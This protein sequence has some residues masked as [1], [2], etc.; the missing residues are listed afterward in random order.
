M[1]HKIVLAAVIFLAFLS[2]SFRVSENLPEMRGEDLIIGA[3]VI[4]M[5]LSGSRKR[6]VG[7]R[8]KITKA[9]VFM[10]FMVIVSISGSVIFFGEE[11]SFADWMIL[12][13]LFRQWVV[14]RIARSAAD[15]G[16][17]SFCL[18]IILI[19]CGI[20]AVVGIMQRHNTVGVNE[21]L[22]PHY[23]SGAMTSVSMEMLIIE[24]AEGRVS[25]TNGDPR[26]YGY[27][28]VAGIATSL[29]CV[30]N[31]TKHSRMKML[32]LLVAALAFTSII[33]TLSRTTIISLLVVLAGAV[34]LVFQRRH[35]LSK[36]LPTVLVVGAIGVSIY[37][38]ITT[39]AF[40]DRVL[41]IDTQSYE[42]HSYARKRDL[43]T[44]F[45]DAMDNPA[46][47]IIGRGPSKS[48]LRQSTHNDF[49]WMFH[50]FGL[51][52]LGFYVFLLW[53]AL[54]GS[55]R[56]YIAAKTGDDRAVTMA[57]FLGTLVWLVFSQAESVFKDTQLMVISMFFL[58]L[59]YSYHPDRSASSTQAQRM[60]V[61]KA[62]C[63]RNIIAKP[64]YSG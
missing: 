2:P 32:S 56:L 46:I 1:I 34:Y 24:R 44:P 18:K 62:P 7:S 43:V 48:S 4:Y 31:L 13:L 3:M 30:L 11:L 20:S 59:L 51:P 37:V 29:A 39:D 61:R 21:W 42:Y 47:W 23:V 12:P 14:F 15:G 33:Y 64:R 19:A 6:Q 58:G 8:D 25:G 52:G 10:G 22:T 57:V 54:T 53:S 9:Y 28:L 36:V 63:P 17:K 26:H 35:Q 55:R 60:S 50:R 5:A 27:L 41:N 45:S 16:L 38:T 40:E 49:G